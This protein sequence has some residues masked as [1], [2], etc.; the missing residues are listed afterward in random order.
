[1]T[2]GIP[3]TKA[4]GRQ[5]RHKNNNLTTLMRKTKPLLSQENICLYKKDMLALMFFL[6]TTTP[7]TYGISQARVKSELHLQLTPQLVA[8]PDP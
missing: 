5:G 7:V 8:M 2:L 3:A 6:F 1:M 4:N